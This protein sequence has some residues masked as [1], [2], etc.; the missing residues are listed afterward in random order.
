VIAGLAALVRLLRP[1]WPRWGVVGGVAL[2]APL[3]V[4]GA[5]AWSIAALGPAPPGETDATGMALAVYAIGGSLLAAAL[6]VLGV[7]AA[8]LVTRPRRATVTQH[9]VVPS[10][11]AKP[12]GPEPATSAT[13]P[14]LHPL[15]PG[16]DA[17]LAP[18]PE[19]AQTELRRRTRTSPPPDTVAELFREVHGWLVG[20]GIAEG[21]GGYP[22]RPG[23][24]DYV[25]EQRRSV[26]VFRAVANAWGEPPSDLA[27]SVDDYD[28]SFPPPERC[29]G[30]GWEPHVNDVA[31][32]LMYEFPV[33]SG[34]MSASFSFPLA[35]CD[36]DVLLADPYRRAA[37]EVVTHTVF[38]RSMIPGNPEVTE[39]EFRALVDTVLHSHANALA[40]YLASFDRE[41]NI[42]ADVYVRQAMAR[43]TAATDDGP[44][45]A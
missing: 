40:A 44:S 16:F 7:A 12:A 14:P 17:L 10:E 29:Q 43:H 19:F 38:Q 22:G 23:W 20:A 18:L 8:W 11:S 15:V 6:L 32:R 42:G 30:D 2:P 25:E 4:L 1:G 28:R 45:A 35:R 27:R 21:R 34:H 37:L 26:A 3:V 24:T 33:D 9:P 39:A 31:G 5:A 41:H 36:L 13:A